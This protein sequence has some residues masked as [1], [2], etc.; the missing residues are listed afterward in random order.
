MT[1]RKKENRLITPFIGKAPILGAIIPILMLIVPALLFMP[2][3]SLWTDE[4]TT[5]SGISLG[6]LEVLQWLRGL[7]NPFDVPTDNMPPVGYWV[8]MLWTNIFGL[9]EISMRYFALFASC[10]SVL[11]VF[12]TARFAFGFKSGLLAGVLYA[13][14][15]NI[16]EQ[17]VNIRVYPIYLLL[18]ACCFYCSIRLIRNPKT[19]QKRWLFGLF[20]FS[21]LTI[22]SHLYGLLPVGSIFLATLICFWKTGGR[23]KLLFLTMAGIGVSAIGLIPFLLALFENLGRHFEKSDVGNL[24]AIIRLIYRQFGHPTM[25]GS[26]LVIGVAALGFLLLFLL[27]LL[28]KPPKREITVTLF[29]ALIAGFLVILLG[30]FFISPLF[31]EIRYNLWMLPGICILLS[32]SILIDSQR[33]RYLAVIAFIM[34]AGADLY[35]ASQFIVNGKY[36]SR[37][38]F[39]SINSQITELGPEHVTIIH[40]GQFGSVYFPIRYTYGNK[41]DQ[42]LLKKNQE[43]QPQLMRLPHLDETVNPVSFKTQYL[44]LLKTE[45]IGAKE[46]ASS[47][48]HQKRRLKKSMV[49]DLLENSKKWEITSSDILI[50]Y[51]QTDMKIYQRID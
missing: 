42:F 49:E 19:Y 3:Q 22:Y 44:V 4:T 26:T 27:A 12:E 39:K 11:V 47:I 33:L 1:P 10:L 24:R 5:L 2:Q 18:S 9:S 32:S 40:D 34:I 14:S 17:A 45:S 36:Y 23:L 46:I 20:F 7:I 37:S 31:T 43:V 15:P 13:L 38:R 29:T 16:I 51:S 8:G 30:R 6:P 28:V 21:I 48:K 35:G 50:S 41:M 25:M